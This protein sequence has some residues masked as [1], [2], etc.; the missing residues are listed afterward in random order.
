MN[1]VQD[2]K[3]HGYTSSDCTSYLYDDPYEEGLT[4]FGKKRW[5]TE[6]Q[7]E[8]WSQLRSN[9]TKQI[10]DSQRADHGVQ[11]RKILGEA[12]ASSNSSGPQQKSA[13][14]V[15]DL[16]HPAIPV[17]A[18]R[19]I[20]FEDHSDS[21]PST[22]SAIFSVWSFGQT[23]NG[24]TR[25][26]SL[27]SV[28]SPRST[29]PPRQRSVQTWLDLSKIGVFGDKDDWYHVVEVRQ[30]ERRLRPDSSQV[31]K[32]DLDL[33]SPIE[34]GNCREQSL[35]IPAVDVRFEPEQSAPGQD[36]RR[37]PPGD[38]GDGEEAHT[39][40]KEYV[41]SAQR[42]ELT[43]SSPCRTMPKEEEDFD[44]NLKLDTRKVIELPELDNHP[45]LGSLSKLQPP[46]TGDEPPGAV[47]VNKMANKILTQDE[48][49]DST[50]RSVEL[51]RDFLSEHHS[52]RITPIRGE[53]QESSNNGHDMATS[54]K[55]RKPVMSQPSG[56][57]SIKR[58]LLRAG[59][60]GFWLTGFSLLLMVVTIIMN[61]QLVKR[62]SPLSQLAMSM[63]GVMTLIALA[64]VIGRFSSS[65][66]ERDVQF[67]YLAG[68]EYTISNFIKRYVEDLTGESWDWWPLQPSFR[69]LRAD[70][71][72]V[73]WCCVSV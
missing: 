30:A 29:S 20:N 10:V 11:D 16:L 40:T 50:I 17:P 53:H 38:L 3:E 25:L 58:E 57:W 64:G 47:H 73:K 1:S 44:M 37:N 24:S 56:R 72:R 26:S 36:L 2:P 28:S 21:E 8:V 46:Q 9:D 51:K 33:E 54:I 5:K 65:Q 63:I 18:T 52:G 14:E 48:A 23:S 31:T 55:P 22:R 43:V 66:R 59:S 6:T 27:G 19:S 60:T 13:R 42:F 15:R 12:T 68:E 70:E 61:N 62:G 7:K 45:D 34:S 71:V 67:R 32:P 41:D 49:N 4:V 69:P 35:S 39:D